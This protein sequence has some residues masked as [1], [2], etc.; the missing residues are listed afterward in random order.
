MAKEA[1]REALEAALERYVLSLFYPSK[2]KK[3]Y[4]HFF[5]K[6]A[7]R[8]KDEIEETKEKERREGEKEKDM[9]RKRERDLKSKR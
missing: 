4:S 1:S 3:I 2:K 6:E 7:I 9:K 8:E 5:T